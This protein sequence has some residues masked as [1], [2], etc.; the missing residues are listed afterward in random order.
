MLAFSSADTDA[1]RFIGNF[2]VLNTVC[3]EKIKSNSLKN[4]LLQGVGF[5][6]KALDKSDHDL[7]LDMFKSEAFR[8]LI[9]VRD[10]LW[11]VSNLFASMVV[12]FECSY[13]DGRDH[14][15]VD[16]SPAEVVEM[17]GH[18]GRPN[19]DN[20]GS[21]VI[22]CH[23]PKQKYFEKFVHTALPVESHLDHVLHNTMCAEVVAKAIT[24]KQEAVDYLTWSY[25]YRRLTKNPN[26]YNLLGT[27]NEELSDHLSELVESTLSDLEESKCIEILNDDT[28]ISPLNLGMISSYHYI[29]YT[30]IELYA[31][32]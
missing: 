26:Y 6:H 3:N 1:D 10:E 27:T 12:V 2:D 29:Q 17:I 30:T 24:S 5:L 9:V 19:K 7:V 25:F 22:M 4:T 18:A 13:Y 32:S 23:K 28:E 8:L 31:S 11:A 20:S 21:S 15:Y 14:R 16:Y